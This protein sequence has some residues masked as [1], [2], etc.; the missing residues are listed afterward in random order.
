MVL[1]YV[2]MI[3]ETS[4]P[5]STHIVEEADRADGDTVILSLRKHSPVQGHSLL[6]A[7]LDTLLQLRHLP[8]VLPLERRVLP[9]MVGDLARVFTKVVSP[10]IE[11]RH[12]AERTSNAQW[13]I[14]VAIVAEECRPGKGRVGGWNIDVDSD[15]I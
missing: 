8:S 4:F 6:R 7:F 12:V 15:E 3:V 13:D 5:L 1:A 10:R 9:V 11:E 2:L 14:L